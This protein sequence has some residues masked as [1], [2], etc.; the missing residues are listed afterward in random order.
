MSF[1]FNPND[2]SSFVLV[3][4]KN[5][6]TICA[7]EDVEAFEEI[8]LEL[9]KGQSQPVVDMRAF[10]DAISEKSTKTIKKKKQ[11][12]MQKLYASRSAFIINWIVENSFHDIKV[13]DELVKALNNEDKKFDLNNIYLIILDEINFP[14]LHSSGLRTKERLKVREIPDEIVSWD[15]AISL[16]PSPIKEEVGNIELSFNEDEEKE[17]KSVH[18]AILNVTTLNDYEQLEAELVLLKNEVEKSRI[19]VI[20]E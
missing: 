11:E 12:A 8:Y 16:L 6:A 2:P 13:H 1:L 7:P 17:T 14:S 15:N 10:L 9:T 5:E 19:G 4:P 20:E 3:V 18:D